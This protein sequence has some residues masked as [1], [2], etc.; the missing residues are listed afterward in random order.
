MNMEQSAGKFDTSAYDEKVAL[1]KR[2][3]AEKAKSKGN[4]EELKSTK[5][6]WDEK[7]VAEAI[8]RMKADEK[9]VDKIRYG[10]SPEKK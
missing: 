7:E 6:G 10:E 5:S 3:V 9:I 2:L 4:G 1:N 8:K